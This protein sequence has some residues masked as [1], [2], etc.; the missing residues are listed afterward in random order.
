[1]KKTYMNEALYNFGLQ[2]IEIH[3]DVQVWIK[4]ALWTLSVQMCYS[5]FISVSYLR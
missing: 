4:I 1:M 3:S 2:M 5:I